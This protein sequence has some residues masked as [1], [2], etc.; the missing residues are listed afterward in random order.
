MTFKI[1]TLRYA[2]KVLGYRYSCCDGSVLHEILAF[3][4][5]FHVREAYEELQKLISITPK[6]FA[7]DVEIAERTLDYASAK[8]VRWAMAKSAWVYLPEEEQTG[9]VYASICAKVRC[10]SMMTEE[11][12][13]DLRNKAERIFAEG[14]EVLLTEAEEMPANCVSF[15]LKVGV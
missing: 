13:K 1:A 3:N 5:A 14:W 8:I 9:K 10:V 11:E 7:N 4:L 12:R 2:V 6:R 15:P